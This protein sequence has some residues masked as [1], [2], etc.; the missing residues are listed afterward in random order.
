MLRQWTHCALTEVNSSIIFV[1]SAGTPGGRGGGGPLTTPPCCTPPSPPTA[2]SVPNTSTEPPTSS[3]SWD[4]TG[5]SSG[6]DS[7]SADGLPC[8]GTE[9]SV[10][11]QGW[12]LVLE[13]TD[14]NCARRDCCGCWRAF[15]TPSLSALGRCFLS[16]LIIG[17]AELLFESLE[18]FRMRT[19]CFSFLADATCCFASFSFLLQNIQ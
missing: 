18:V 6:C 19:G 5:C 2:A 16:L 4:A 17:V 14:S 8:K 13:A 11:A 15:F 3:R 9:P 10:L 12:P 1:R 7:A